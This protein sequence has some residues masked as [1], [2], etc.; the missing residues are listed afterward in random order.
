MTDTLAATKEEDDASVSAATSKKRR[1][2]GR[3]TRAFVNLLDSAIKAQDYE[4]DFTI[5]GSTIQLHR[6]AGPASKQVMYARPPKALVIHLGRSSFGGY[7][8]GQ[9]NNCHVR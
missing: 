9:K 7:G 8:Y 6:S 1:L 3:E 4:R 5:P 2:K